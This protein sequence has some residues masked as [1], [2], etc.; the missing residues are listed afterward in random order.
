MSSPGSTGTARIRIINY[1]T[2]TFNEAEAHSIEEW[3]ASAKTPT[4]T[5]IAV[6]GPNTPE[7]LEVVKQSFG[8]HALVLEDIATTS[9]S[10]RKSRC[11]TTTFLSWCACSATTIRRRRPKRRRRA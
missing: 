3:G 10:P 7:L 1:D 9:Q 2:R 6:E 11:S 5:W 4:V 8:V